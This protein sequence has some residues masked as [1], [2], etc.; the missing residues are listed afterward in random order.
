[1]AT[2]LCH[3]SAVKVV[4]RVISTLDT[5]PKMEKIQYSRKLTVDSW[6]YT[7]TIWLTFL[8][9]RR[10]RPGFR[11]KTCHI[12]RL[13]LPVLPEKLI[14]CYHSGQII[15][16][17]QNLSE[18]AHYPSPKG[19]SR[20]RLQG[21]FICFNSVVF[22]DKICFRAYSL[23]VL[24]VGADH[25]R[26]SMFWRSGYGP[27]QAKESGCVLPRYRDVSP[28]SERDFFRF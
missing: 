7:S 3:T 16:A 4:F 21:N 13:A 8:C 9:C 28:A 14:T 26:A 10:R 27:V 25:A 12:I 5:K 24:Y 6:R 20:S 22:H 17:V 15:R 2:F 23:S 11:K 18:T 1:M 19:T